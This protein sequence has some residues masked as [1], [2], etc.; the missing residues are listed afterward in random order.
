MTLQKNIH[1]KLNLLFFVFLNSLILSKGYADS[2]PPPRK[3]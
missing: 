2:P 1:L 3:K